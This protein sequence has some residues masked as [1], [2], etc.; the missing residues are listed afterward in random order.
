MIDLKAINDWETF[1][2]NCDVGGISE[3]DFA[4]VYAG[5]Q[6]KK[7]H[8]N[9][10]IMAMSTMKASNGAEVLWIYTDETRYC[11]IIDIYDKEKWIK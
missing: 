3:R 1:E 2:E 4:L 6:L 5:I 9:E 8:P 10:K 11:T 7:D